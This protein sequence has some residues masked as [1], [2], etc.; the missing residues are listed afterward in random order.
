M[1]I[2]GLVPAYYSSWSI[3]G[4]SGVT[5]TIIDGEEVDF[6]GGTG[7]NTVVTTAGSNSIL[8]INNTGVTSII[9]GTNITV[10]QATG[11]VTINSADQYVGTVTSVGSGAGL[12]GGPI[13]T[14]VL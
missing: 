6:A 5:Q 12:T 10:N 11:Q 9:A 7:I 14:V 4:D 8:T 3:A 2:L 13:T 1:I